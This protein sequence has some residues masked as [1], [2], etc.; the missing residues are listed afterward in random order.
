MA[1]NDIIIYTSKDGK[2]E[3]GLTKLGDKIW[4]TQPD[5]AKLFGTSVANISTHIKNILDDKEL[6][7]Y[8]TIKNYLRVAQ[9]GGREVE[10]EAPIYSLEMILAVGFRVRS[11]RAVEFR[12]WAIAF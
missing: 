1:E 5:I 4:L 6:S 10:R 3:I 7:E 12:Q 9:E 11:Q 8:S 2:T